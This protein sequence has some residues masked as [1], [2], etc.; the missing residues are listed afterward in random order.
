[1]SGILWN[2]VSFIVALGILV[3]VHEY[4]HF[5]VARKCGVKVEK[6]SIGF[7]KSIW[8]RLGKDGTE[9][10]ISIIPLGGYVKM[11]DG[12]VDDVS[13]QDQQFAFDKKPLWKRAAIVSAGPAFNFFF[14]VFAYWL[15]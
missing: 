9:Y 5:W 11:L 13:P 7:G 3:A 14:A 15:V 2:L 4:G 8:K 6:F 10:S 12:R 1:M